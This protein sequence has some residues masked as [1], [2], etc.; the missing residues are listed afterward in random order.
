M[1]GLGHRGSTVLRD[2]SMLDPGVV[3]VLASIKLELSANTHDN[4]L[5]NT[6][7]PRVASVISK[8]S[9]VMLHQ[10]MYARWQGSGATDSPQPAGYRY[11]SSSTGYD[12][13]AYRDYR[14]GGGGPSGT[15]YGGGRGW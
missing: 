2:I 15:T 5:L 8:P 1:P 7:P 9:P 14:G 3:S 13:S 4:A 6:M 11:P 10:V 12:P